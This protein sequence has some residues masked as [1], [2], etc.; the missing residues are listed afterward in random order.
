MRKNWFTILNVKVTL[1][2]YIIK[3]D[4]FLLY[5]LKSGPFATKLGLICHK[6]GHSC[7]KNGLLRSRLRSQRRHNMLVNVCLDSIF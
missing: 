2:A 5:L 4:Y 6:L 7:G 1:R 3:H